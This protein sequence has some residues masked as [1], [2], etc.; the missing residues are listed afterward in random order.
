M[1][2]LPTLPKRLRRPDSRIVNYQKSS[3][4]ALPHS[5]V[6]DPL[7][8]LSFILMLHSHSFASKFTFVFIFSVAGFRLRVFSLADSRCDCLCPRVK[9]CHFASVDAVTAPSLPH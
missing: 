5:L 9:Q 6:I 3:F 8:A 4:A 2:T 7:V 1:S